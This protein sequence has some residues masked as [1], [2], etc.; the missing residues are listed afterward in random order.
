MGGRVV[1]AGHALKILEMYLNT[2][3]EG[4]RHARRV[5]MLGDLEARR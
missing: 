2:P 1:G 4:G 3:F 5:S